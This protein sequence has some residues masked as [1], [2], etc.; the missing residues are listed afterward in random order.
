MEDLKRNIEVLTRHE[1]GNINRK[2]P[3]NR[4]II[5]DGH[6]SDDDQIAAEILA[7]HRQNVII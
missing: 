3:W 6:R 5:I 7:T 2:V 4:E 1:N